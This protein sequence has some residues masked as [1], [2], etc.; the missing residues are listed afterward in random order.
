LS[1]ASSPG[2]VGALGLRVRWMV[3]QRFILHC[4]FESNNRQVI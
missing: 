4:Q 3:E 1:G 2:T